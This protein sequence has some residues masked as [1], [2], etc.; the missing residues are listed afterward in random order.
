MNAIRFFSR[1]LVVLCL[2]ALSACFSSS[3][4]SQYYT[5][6]ALQRPGAYQHVNSRFT[7][8]VGPVF[9]PDILKRP[10]IAVRTN[11]NQVDFSE[12]HKWAGALKDDAKRMITENLSILLAE[13]GATVSTDDLLIEPDLR[14]VVNI[15]RFDGV[16][17]ENASLNAVWTLKD[18]KNQ[19]II[20]M[21]QSLYSEKISGRNYADLVNAQSRTLQLLSREIAAEIIKLR[22]S[23]G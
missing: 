3:Q 6:N 18:Q 16:P 11:D 14:V 15:N 20:A 4:P 8:S 5:L 9:L 2:A 7:V 21:N 17:G 23:A 13:E 10:Q 1:L 19:K 12:F 22:K